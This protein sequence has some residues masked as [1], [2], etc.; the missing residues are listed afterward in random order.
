MDQ[1]RLSEEER[2]TKF[3][4]QNP[5]ID[6]ILAKADELALAKWHLCAGYL[7]QS[8]WNTVFEFP[9]EHEIDDI[10]LIYFYT[11]DLSDEAEE[12]HAQQAL[13]VF[14]DLPVRLDVKKTRLV[15]IFGMRVSSEKSSCHSN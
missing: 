9:A 10:D 15:S 14:P 2:F 12:N 1:K 4:Y 5:L 13:S 3:L 6:T 7:T 11:D 8:I